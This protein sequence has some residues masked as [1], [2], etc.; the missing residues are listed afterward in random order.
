LRDPPYSMR[1]L[2]RGQLRGIDLLDVQLAGVAHRLE[3]EAQRAGAVEQQAE[4]LVEHEHRGVSAPFHFG[5]HELQGDRALAGPRG[6]QDQRARSALDAA[7]EQLI[8]PWNL[9]LDR[10]AGKPAVVLG[11]DQ[12][13]IDLHTAGPDGEVVVAAADRLAAILGDSQPTPLGAE[14]RC[15]L[16]ETDDAMDDAVRGLVAI[17]GRAIVE[18]YHGGAMAREVVLECEDLAPVA[19]RILREQAD[20]REAVDHHPARP[21]A[22]EGPEDRLRHL[23]ELEVGRIQQALLLVGVEEAFGRHE[24]EHLDA[25]A[26][27]PAVRR[28]AV[29]Q[30]GLGL[31]QRR[32]ETALAVLRALDQEAQRDCRLAGPGVALDQEHVTVGKAAGQHVV[33][34]LDAGARLGGPR[35]GR[36]VHRRSFTAKRDSQDSRELTWPGPAAACRKT[37]RE[38]PSRRRDRPRSRARTRSPRIP[39]DCSTSRQHSLYEC[40]ASRASDPS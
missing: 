33:E 1:E 35:G 40:R 26:E 38:R 3:I 12:S 36:C 37:C 32:I 17:L 39:I 34:A 18:H 4:L 16:L 30:L 8:E 15:E 10:V 9:A 31:R 6:T 11:R 29:A 2:A 7:A 13:W 19:K 23:A 25:V 24:L 27:G 5:G 14:R 28:G 22:L 20:F 21:D